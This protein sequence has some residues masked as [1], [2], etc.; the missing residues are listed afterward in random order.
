[1]FIRNE[2]FDLILIITVEDTDNWRRELARIAEMVGL[3]TPDEIVEMENRQKTPATPPQVPLS[4]SVRS[5]NT[6]GQYSLQ[7]G[8]WNETPKSAN[9]CRSARRRT[10]LKLFAPDQL[11]CVDEHEREM[12]V[13][14]IENN[15]F[16][17][18]ERQ[19]ACFRSH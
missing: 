9:R 6:T 2:N 10:P 13:R 3:M 8:R 17:E 18:R 19:F 5:A 11:Y 1:M 7:S 15:A 16:E 4:S 12:W 14:R